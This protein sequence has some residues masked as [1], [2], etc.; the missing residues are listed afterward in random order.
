MTSV[1]PGSVVP[2]PA[3]AATTVTRA[4]PPLPLSVVS[5][6]LTTETTDKAKARPPL[7]QRQRR[8]MAPI[9]YRMARESE[10]TLSPTPHYYM[11]QGRAA[12]IA[13]ASGSPASGAE[14]L[15]LAMLHDGGWPVSAISG[16]IDLARAETAVRGI[17]DSPGYSPPPRPVF[18]GFVASGCAQE[19]WGAKTAAA[20]GDS[21]LGL[22]HAFLAMIRNRETVAAR[23]LAGLA[24]L[25]ALEA[26][27]VA[28][29]SAPVGPAEDAA[30]LPEGQRLDS[31]LLGAI[32]DALPEGATFGF[33]S[34]GDRSWVDVFGP[35]GSLGRDVSREVLNTA[36]ISLG[37][38]ALNS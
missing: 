24:D 35:D 13:R 27:V 16:L 9:V 4:I 7:A 11:V 14:H 25:D 3:G 38:P 2:L 23:A 20:M 5:V 21:H 36:L 29:A 17:L 1:K 22:E 10:G 34:A 12:E 32:S 19:L 33:N 30:V 26:A 18:P 6:V 15:F 8:G 37:R 31:P 28:A